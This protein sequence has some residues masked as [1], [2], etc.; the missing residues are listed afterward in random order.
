MIGLDIPVLDE[1]Q[2]VGAGV[3]PGGC[4][5]C[6]STDR[7][8][9]IYI[10]LKEKFKIFD[11]GK[12]KSILHIAPEN[13]LSNKLLEFGFSNYVCGDLFAEGYTYPGHVQN[14]NLLNLPFS[15][16]TFDLVICNHVLEHIPNDLQ[17]MKEIYRVLKTG[18]QAIV[19]V[20]ISKNSS[21]TLEDFSI[22]DPKEREHVF[23]QFDHVRIYG[24]DYVD[25]LTKSGFTINRVNISKEYS[26]YG[27]NS[28]EDLF[29][30]VK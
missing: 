29:I 11:L 6:G 7:D 30:A 18:D 9:L 16:N 23:G 19:Q 2:V 5:N 15:D 26:Y 22:T 14:M 28:Q 3:R 10:Y 20:P 27:L 12:D 17:A 21:I 1:K 24:Q 4:Y 13:I 8:R 25:R